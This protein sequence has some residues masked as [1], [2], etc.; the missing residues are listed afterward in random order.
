MRPAMALP[1]SVL[2]P[3]EA[4]E[5]MAGAARE[6]LARV[7]VRVDRTGG[8]GADGGGRRAGPP[9]RLCPPPPS[10]APSPDPRRVHAA[11]PRRREV[12]AGLPRPRR[13]LR[14]QQRRGPA[15]RRPRHGALAPGDLGRP[16]AGRPCHAPLALPADDQLAVLA[17]RRAGRAAA[18]LL[19]PRAG[20]RDR[21]APGFALHRL[22][23]AARAALRHGRGGRGRSPRP[24]PTPSTSRSRR[25]APC[26]SAPRSATVCST[27]PAATSPSRSCPARWAA[28]RPR[29]RWPA[30]SS[31]STPRCWPASCW[32]RPSGPARP[33]SPACGWGRVTRAAASSWAAR[34]K[35]RWPRSG[36]TQLARRDG[37][38][39]DC[40]APRPARRSSRCRPA[41]SR[42][43]P[44]AELH[45][46]TSLPVGLRH[47]AGH[48]L[49]LE[50]LVVHDQL[51]AHRPTA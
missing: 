17:R 15:R 14:P 20:P 31:C 41:S 16:G 7:G 29:P 50:A 10:T 28:P 5:A 21:Q 19:V 12:G 37:L 6:I 40:T 47:H 26:S 30:A 8:R 45:G 22:R 24:P 39:C 51:F 44:P 9:G 3:D 18:P 32:C 38:A 43:H 4:I 27:R 23:L 25:S 33:A 36:A 49:C 11:G 35:G 13:D 42:A 34:P 46:A 1:T 48:G 2:W